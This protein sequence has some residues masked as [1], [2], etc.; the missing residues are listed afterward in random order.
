MLKSLIGFKV[1]TI[2]DRVVLVTDGIV[3]SVLLAVT[4]GAA[5]GVVVVG[6]GSPFVVDSL[7]EAMEVDDDAFGFTVV[8]V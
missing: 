4:F 7:D 3:K 1:T 6:V 5:T 8:V 2:G